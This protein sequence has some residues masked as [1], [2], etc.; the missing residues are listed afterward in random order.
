MDMLRRAVASEFRNVEWM[1]RD[2]D[3]DLLRTRRDF[4]DVMRDLAPCLNR[5]LADA[6]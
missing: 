5:P 1:R 2:P 6:R 3:L 4:Q